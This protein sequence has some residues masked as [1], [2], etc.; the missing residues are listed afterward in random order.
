[1]AVFRSSPADEWISN[2]RGDDVSADRSRTRSV[3]AWLSS[4]S[5]RCRE[6]A[7]GLPSFQRVQFVGRRGEILPPFMRLD[8]LFALLEHEMV[9]RVE[10]MMDVGR[11]EHRLS[12]LGKHYVT[13]TR[14]PNV[15]MA[16]ATQTNLQALVR[17]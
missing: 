5:A 3:V 11:L 6:G 8:P 7:S 13:S 1:L 12:N 4:P 17:A 15:G 14:L 2:A 16:L 10:R 9:Q